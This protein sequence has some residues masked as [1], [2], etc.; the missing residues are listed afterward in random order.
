[1]RVVEGSQS[2]P[3]VAT[4][5]RVTLEAGRR[6]GPLLTVLDEAARP[7]VK[8]GTADEIFLVANRS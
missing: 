3:S 2:T 6:A 5:G 7:E 8:Q 4:L 1:M